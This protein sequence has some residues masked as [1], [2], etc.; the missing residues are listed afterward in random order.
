MNAASRQFRLVLAAVGLLRRF[1]GGVFIELACRVKYTDCKA[2]NT[3]KR[4]VTQ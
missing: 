3:N 1:L 2:N 4:N